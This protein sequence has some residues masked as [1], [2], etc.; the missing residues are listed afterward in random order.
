MEGVD[1]LAK[2]L[3]ISSMRRRRRRWVL[4][5][6]W[7]LGWVGRWVLRRL[8]ISSMGRCRWWVLGWVGRWVLRCLVI[9]SMRRWRWWVLGWV[10]WVSW[11]GW[12][13]LGWWVLRCWWVLL[14]CCKSHTGKDED[15]GE[16]SFCSHSF[17]EMFPWWRSSSVSP[18]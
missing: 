3:V 15:K 1:A 17:F 9:S 16:N 18:C 2:R 12:W 4:G 6:W 5:R 11:V 13:V 14:A 7:V 10:S 8:V